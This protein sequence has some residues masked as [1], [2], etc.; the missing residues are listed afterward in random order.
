M[1]KFDRCCQNNFFV[2]QEIIAKEILCC[3]V[4]QLKLVLSFISGFNSRVLCPQRFYVLSYG[5][6]KSSGK[7]EF[8]HSRRSILLKSVNNL[9]MSKVSDF[10]LYGNTQIFT[11]SN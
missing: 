5:R 10:I 7:V 4:V 9:F 6:S 11:R 1:M 2:S 3:R 8:A